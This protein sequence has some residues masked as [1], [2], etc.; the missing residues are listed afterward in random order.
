MFNRGFSITC[1]I[2]IHT[3][4]QPSFCSTNSLSTK[5]KTRE[6]LY[7]WFLFIWNLAFQI[8]I[9]II[10]LVLLITIYLILI[11]R[12]RLNFFQKFFENC[13]PLISVNGK[14]KSI[15][16]VSFLLLSSKEFSFRS[17]K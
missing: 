14:R 10:N 2:H 15:T 8:S 11:L 17:S 5:A 4:Y 16:G 9:E 3:S 13:L 6:Y 7:N 1:T 12:K